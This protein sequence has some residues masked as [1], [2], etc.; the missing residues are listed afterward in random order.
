LD[1]TDGKH[2]VR[3]YIAIKPQLWRLQL[4]FSVANKYFFEMSKFFENR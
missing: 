4:I 1:W 2:H 3:S